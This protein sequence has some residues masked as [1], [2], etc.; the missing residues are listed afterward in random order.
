MEENLMRRANEGQD[1][2]DGGVNEPSNNGSNREEVEI[3]KELVF[4]FDYSDCEDKKVND[5]HVYLSEEYSSDSHHSTNR[6][7]VPLP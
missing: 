5:V 1:A 7:K 3:S 2:Q 6:S 4:G